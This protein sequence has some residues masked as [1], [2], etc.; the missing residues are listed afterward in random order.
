VYRAAVLYK[1]PRVAGMCARFGTMREDC[2]IF[3]DIINAPWIEKPMKTSRF[4]LQKLKKQGQ[5]LRFTEN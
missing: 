2:H 3:E 5:V 4:F 1:P